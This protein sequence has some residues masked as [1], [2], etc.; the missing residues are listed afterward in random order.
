MYIFINLIKFLKGAQFVLMNFYK[1]SYLNHCPA[2]TFSI[3]IASINGWKWRKIVI[4][5]FIFFPLK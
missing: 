1:I 4:F 5:N 3:V 2:N